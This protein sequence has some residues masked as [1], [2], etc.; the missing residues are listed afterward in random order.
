MQLFNSNYLFCATLYLL[1]FIN[2]FCNL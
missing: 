1:I 2:Y